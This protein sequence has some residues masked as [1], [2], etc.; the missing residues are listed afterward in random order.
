[1]SLSRRFSTRLNLEGLED[2]AVPAT[3]VTQAGNVLNIVGDGG[4]NIV[5]ISDSDNSIQVT[6]DGVTQD[7]VGV[8]T[9][10]VDTF[11]GTDIVNYNLVDEE[12]NSVRTLSVELGDGNDFFRAQAIDIAD[13]GSGGNLT[14]DVNGQKGNDLIQ[15]AYTEDFDV[16]SGGNLSVT[17]NGDKGKDVMTFTQFGEQDGNISVVLVGGQDR[18]LIGINIVAEDD[19]EGNIFVAA[20]GQGGN[21]LLGVLVHT[22]TDFT[23]TLSGFATGDAGNDDAIVS[24]F[25]TVLGVNVGD[26]LRI[27]V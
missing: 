26:T 16:R 2:R 14:M 19:S 11:G 7:F 8:Q 25:V 4:T 24:D 18:D 20:V 17:A 1:M 21:D 15:F 23:G 12:L 9:I 13:I 6:A 5:T 10:N 22:D 3:S 27:P